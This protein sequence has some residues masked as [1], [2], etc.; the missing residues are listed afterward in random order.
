MCSQVCIDIQGDAYRI[1][2]DRR[3]RGGG[4]KTT[5]IPRYVRT[6]LK[7]T[8]NGRP[9]AMLAV[10]CLKASQLLHPILFCIAIL[11]V[12]YQ[13]YILRCW[14]ACMGIATEWDICS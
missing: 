12:V 1:V 10:V 5:Q 8:A 3:Q 2:G 9:Q 4:D 7:Q 11:C 13:N 6:V 14:V